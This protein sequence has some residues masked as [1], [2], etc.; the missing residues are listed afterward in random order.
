MKITEEER[1]QLRRAYHLEGK[2]I[3]QLA[4]QG[5]LWLKNLRSA[6]PNMEIV[7]METDSPCF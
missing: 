1:E 2:S 7:F 5:P 3:G 4:R 6:I